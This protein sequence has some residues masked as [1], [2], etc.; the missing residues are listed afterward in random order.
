MQLNHNNE[1]SREHPVNDMQ[2]LLHCPSLICA[3]WAMD[4]AWLAKFRQHAVLPEV[5]PYQGNRRLGFYYQWLWQQLIE[6]HPHYRLLAEEV[7]LT[8][9][10]QTLGAIDFLVENTQTGHLEHWE[11]AIKFYLAFQQQWPGPN[12]KDNL[13]KKTNRMLDH[14]LRLSEHPAFIEQLAPK[15]GMPHTKRLLMQGRL[16]YPCH[17]ND[18]G[19]SVAINPQALTGHW[20]YPAQA[21]PLA[22]KPIEK[23]QWLNPP[24][25]HELETLPDVAAVTAPTQAIAPDN[26]VWFVMPEDW[27]HRDGFKSLENTQ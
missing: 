23:S 13:D 12:A 10:K 6:A 15:Y 5:A 3:P 27:P 9:H 22:L 1:T 11:V 20:C 18:R 17:H 21:A 2:T 14:Q 16:F 19:S 26:Q 7:Q 24:G 25:Y 8:W 4:E